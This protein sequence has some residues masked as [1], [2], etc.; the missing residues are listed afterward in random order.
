MQLVEL[1]N[2]YEIYL[3]ENEFHGEPESLYEPMNYVMNLGGKRIRPILTILGYKTSTTSMEF[4]WDLAHTMEVFHN[5]TLVHDDIMDEA[6][7][8][9]GKPTVHI[10]YSM[11]TAILAGDNMLILAFNK[12]L[13]SNYTNKYEILELF[14]QTAQQ[15]CDGQQLD[16][17]FELKENV[18][19]D[20][21]LK[22]IELKTA[23]LLG[24]CLKSGALA[25]NANANTQKALYDFGIYSGLAF[26]IMDDI[27]DTFGNTQNTGKQSGGDILA[28]KKMILYHLAMHYGNTDQQRHLKE[29]FDKK[30]TNPETRL[31]D[32]MQILIDLEIKSKAEE[33][34]KTYFSK[35]E[36]TVLHSGI[37]ED[38]YKDLLLLN[39]FLKERNS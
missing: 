39:E 29:L 31:K 23:V 26:Q 24:C 9:R 25:A 16:M 8:R 33:M 7:S 22:M 4:P 30:K 32:T 5:F 3:K 27:L 6:P 15:I 21:Y 28:A 20:D 12:L 17:D 14:T 13:K 34:M 37:E 36:N 38:K 18:S 35:A 19:L 11:P 10:R 1:K 2:L